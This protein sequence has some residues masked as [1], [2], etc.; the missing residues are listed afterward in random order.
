MGLWDGRRDLLPGGGEQSCA[1]VHLILTLELGVAC[2]RSL[3]APLLDSSSGP[4][5]L[6]SMKTP[7]TRLDN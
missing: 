4:A 7:R 3:Q 6:V 5:G 2:V 1:E